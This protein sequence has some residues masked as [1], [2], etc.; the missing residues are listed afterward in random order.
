MGNSA[1]IINFNLMCIPLTTG[2]ANRN[3]DAPRF[4]CPTCHGS[5]SADLVTSVY[6]GM[7]FT[8]EKVQPV[9]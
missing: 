4:A 6:H 9:V 3:K 5:F 7:H 8:L 2:G 1:Q